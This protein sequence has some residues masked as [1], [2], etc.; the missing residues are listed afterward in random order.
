VLQHLD[1][2]RLDSALRECRR[3]LTPGGRLIVSVYNYEYW[4]HRDAR[5]VIDAPD[6]LYVRK[7]SAAEFVDL[8]AAAGFRRARLD[9][10]KAVPDG[11]HVPERLSEWYARFDAFVCRWFPRRGGC[12]LLYEGVRE[13]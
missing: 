2:A 13:G 10:Y 9:T 1:A 4:R 11:G 6:H 8:A 5:T 12:Y 7:F 3:V